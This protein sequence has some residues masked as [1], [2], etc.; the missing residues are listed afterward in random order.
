[1]VGKV[2]A[3]A[4]QAL[5]GLSLAEK[6]ELLAR[7]LQGKFEQSAA[8]FPLSHGQRGLWFLH[9]MDPQSSAYNVC[10]SSRIRS[11]LDIRAFHRAV[12]DLINRHPSLRT[13]FEER[14]G[15]LRQRVRETP[16][17]PLELIDASSWSE[18]LLRSRLDEE[19]HRP[20]DLERGPL[21]RMQ[22]FRRGDADHIFLVG[23]HHIIGDFWSLTLLVEEMQALYPAECNGRPAA[24]AAP[25]QQYH[26]FVS[27]QAEMLTGPEGNR[28]WEYWKRRLDGAPMVLDLPTDRPRPP[29]FSRRG[30]AIPWRVAPKLVNRLK[31]LAASQGTTLY[32]VLLAAFQVQLRR[33]TGQE[34]FLVGCPFAGRSRAGFERVIGYFIN[35]LPLRADLTG[36]PPFRTLL[37][38]VGN[39]LVDGLQHGDYPFPL[40][41][42]RLLIERDPS[43]APLVQASFTLEKAHRSPQLAAWRFF[44]PPSGA[45]LTLGDLRI[46]QYYIEQRT[47]Q[48]DLEMVIE[49]GDGTVEGMLRYNKDLFEPET[50]RRMVGHFLTLLDGIADGP[51]R[52]LSELPWFTAAER[53]LVLYDWNATKVDFPPGLCLHNL[54]EQQAARTP[55]AIA[56]C[57][58]ALGLTYAELKVC[59]NRLAHRLHRMGAGPGTAVALCF[60]RS[61]EMIVAILG[62]LKA[63]AAY[64]PV[65][66]NAPAERLRMILADA[67][68]RMVVTRRS[69]LHRLPESAAAVLCVDDPDCDSDDDLGSRPPESG[70]RSDDLAYIMYTSGSTGRPKGVMVEHRAICNTIQWRNKDL[71]LHASDVVLNNLHYAFD[72]SLGLIFP[73]LAAGARIVLAEPGEEYDPHRLLERVITEGVTIL[74]MPPGLLRVMLDDPLLKVCRK[75]RWVCCGG[76]TMPTDLPARLFELPDVELYNL[77]GPTETAVDATCWACR[78]DGP[79]PVVPIGRPIANVQ[80]YVLDGQGQPVAPGVPGELYIGG[81]GLARG[82]LNAPDLTAERFVP[83]PFSDA[84]GARLY[85]TG[86]RCRWLADG[87]IEFLGRLDHQ[88]KLRGYRIEPCEVETALLG[89]PAVREAAVV[90]HAGTAGSSR[91]VAYVVGYAESEPLNPVALRRHLKDRLPEYMVPAAFVILA[92][93]PRTAGGKLDRS[94]LPAPPNERPASAPPFVAPVTALEVYIASLWREMLG[95]DQ[96][97]SSDN[98]FE[99]GG[100]SI[101][102]AVVM[103]R[104]QE[105]IGHRVSVIA[106]FDSPTVAGLAR[107]LAEAYP[108]IIRPVFGP[109]SLPTEPGSNAGR[110]WDETSKA[111]RPKLAELLVRLQPEGS[112]TPWFMVHPPG[113]IVVCY[114]ALAQRLSRKRPFYGIRSRGLHG[115]LDLPGRLEEMA[116]EYVAAI[117]TV[118]SCGPYLLG[119]WSAGGLV[120]L[121]MAQQ[122]SAQGEEMTM[123]AL[124]DTIPETVDDPNWADRPGV[125]YGLDLSL[126]QLSRL[127]PDEQLPYL[128]QHALR[129]GLVESNVPMSLAQQ[130]I[131]DLKRVFHHHMVLTDH[132]VV[133][134]YPGRITLLRPSDAPIAVPVPHDRGWGKL[135]VDVDVHL[136]P[137]Q[138]HSMV[139]EPHVQDLARTLEG[140]LRRLQASGSGLEQN[141]A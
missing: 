107:E 3:V 118:Q 88:V 103:A 126:E 41:V 79:R 68:T 108:D 80:T 116:E 135:A 35:M 46:E 50:V 53:K 114:H 13:T 14:D 71:T 109:E 97:G 24:L 51:D 123:L 69:L 9:Q 47:S 85:Q 55:D 128:W 127:G 78:R 10:Y 49:E 60:H 33:Y 120:A 58:D 12:R 43:R 74:E 57:G 122:F 2:E 1:M 76:A 141:S 95:V 18:E 130:V 75:L 119:G 100:N 104:L 38:R 31:A 25:T 92:A 101:Q 82:Y 84:P 91:L 27:W 36:D 133:R 132:Y 136:V 70:V 81:A 67:Q 19:A 112:R 98:F 106:L 131:D 99:L 89:H 28:L 111:R 39:T 21:L 6:R 117:R 115:E 17:Q 32:A 96:V 20:Y 134:P 44:L 64:L 61:P 63:G 72:P 105:K 90:V 140:C 138:H 83:D 40:L 23:V 7:L 94:S 125:E 65:D 42:E 22:L 139:K 73:T 45:K 113:G 30:G 11:P 86:D 129:L 124:L 121:E 59:S 52:R 54:F 102:G 4:T 15:V 48:S 37:G 5:A 8:V 110:P 29:V 34:D 87:A 16:P 56:V 137:G 93:L 62:T 26:D 66:P 77:Y